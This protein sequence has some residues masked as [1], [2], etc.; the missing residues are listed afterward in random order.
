VLLRNYQ[1]DIEVKINEIVQKIKGTMKTSIE[2]NA[3]P[4]YQDI[5]EKYQDKKILPIV[6][7]FVDI[8]QSKKWQ[9]EYEEESSEWIIN[10]QSTEIGRIKIQQKKAIVSIPENEISV[11]LNVGKDK[12]NKKNFEII[13]LL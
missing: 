3:E 11:T 2:S 6:V 8:A 13:N 9:V 10:K 12:V 4:N 7:R 1:Y 5:L